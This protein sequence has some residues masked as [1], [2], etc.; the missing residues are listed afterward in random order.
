MDQPEKHPPGLKVLFFT[1]MWERFSFYTMAAVFMYYLRDQ[2]WEAAGHT[3]LRDY[4]SLINGLY[5]GTVYFSPFFGGILA[6]RKVGYFWSIVWGAVFFCVGQLLLAVPTVY[7]LFFGLLG[8]IIGN[9]LF[10]PNISTLV[11]KLYPQGDPR[12]DDAYTIFYM[13]INIGAL[14]APFVA[15]YLRKRYGFHAAFAAA[16]VGMVICLAIFVTFRHLLVLTTAREAT[17]AAEQE[18]EP[19]AEVQR[20]RHAALLIVFVIVALFW[21]AFKQNAITLPLWFQNYTDRSS[22]RALHGSPVVDETNRFGAEL[23][24][25]IN[26]F[27]VIAFSPLLV[28]FWSRLRAR[29]SEP[30][31]PTKVGLGMLFGAA[32]FTVLAVAGLA[33]AD[34]EFHRQQPI[35]AELRRRLDALKDVEPKEA[36]EARRKELLAIQAEL[37]AGAF[38]GPGALAQRLADLEARPPPEDPLEREKSERR[39]AR[40]KLMQ[41]L[42]AVSGPPGVELT[43]VSPWFLVGAYVFIT[44]GELCVSPLGLS[45]VSKLAAR[46]SRAGWMGGW[47]AATAVGGYLSGL[48]GQFWSVW[49]PS[50]FFGFLTGAVLFAAL[51]L[52]IFLRRLNA[53]MAVKA[54]SPL[55]APESAPPVGAA[56]PSDTFTRSGDARG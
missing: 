55:P 7:S 39:L 3:W 8:L 49:A 47:F 23:N 34:Q 28:L 48:I 50:R 37:D 54:A 25:S 24:A 40:L 42:S 41:D 21:M 10:K 15:T 26:P 18:D 52:L 33:G 1:E 19:P 53:A 45:L 27:F 2:Q 44:L 51:L 43:Q 6:D 13:G 32:G 30:T 14:L 16:G 4:A 38:P 46:R 9:G 5:I 12:R 31:T 36:R 22:P 20:N 56:T 29:G 11:G 35:R 17:A